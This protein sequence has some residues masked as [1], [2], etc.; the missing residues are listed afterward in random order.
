MIASTVIISISGPVISPSTFDAIHLDDRFSWVSK[1][2]P[3]GSDHLGRCVL[4]RTIAATYTSLF[5]SV[6]ITIAIVS[7]GT[8]IGLISAMKAGFTDR[9]LM[10]ITDIFQSFPSLLLTLAVV[11]ITGPS[12]YGAAL[13]M[14]L[15]GWPLF[16]RLS[17]NIALVEKSREYCLAARSIGAGNLYIA[18]RHILPQVLRT[19]IIMTGYETRSV[20][21]SLSALGFLGLAGPTGSPDLGS[22]IGEYMVYFPGHPLLLAVPGIAILYLALGFN[23]LGE[24]ISGSRDA[25]D[26]TLV[27]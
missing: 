26:F 11:S 2:Y 23:L 18:F 7:S 12:R 15:S 16:C 19:V 27:I 22:M 3:L 1:E 8:I 21:L 13:G 4:S 17:R 20:I 9:I 25:N 14:L 5:L 6:L 24:G 10:R